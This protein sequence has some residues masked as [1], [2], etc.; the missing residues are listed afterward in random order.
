MVTLSVRQRR[1][2]CSRSRLHTVTPAQL[3]DAQ[4][5]AQIRAAL[6]RVLDAEIALGDACA[7]PDV[8]RTELLALARHVRDARVFLARLCDGCAVNV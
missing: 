5:I 8:A 2:R 1:R 6:N 4:K 7:D 3:P